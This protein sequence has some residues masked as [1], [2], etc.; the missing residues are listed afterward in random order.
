MLSSAA[1]L[2][3]LR[4]SL[5]VLFLIFSETA[6][7]AQDPP[8]PPAEETGTAATSSSDIID[9]PVTMF[10]HSET[11]RFWIS[12]QGNVVLQWHS[13][14]HAKYSGPNSLQSQAENA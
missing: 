13:S 2:V 11:S 8:T 9:S 1:L 7:F 12:G 3:P 5:L 6:S 4:L 14:F 10:P